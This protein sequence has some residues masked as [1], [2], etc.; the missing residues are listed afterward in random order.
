[1]DIKLFRLVERKHSRGGWLS[2]SSGTDNIALEN[3]W[4]CELT[5]Q[6][7]AW[8]NLKDVDICGIVHYRRFFMDYKLNSKK[9]SDDILSKSV[10]EEIFN[11]DRYDI[12]VPYLSSKH[13]GS[14]VLYKN[15]PLEKQDKHWVIIDEII[16]SKYPDYYKSFKKV[17]YGK[18]QL[19]WNMFIA[20]K[21]IFSSYSEW[22]FDVLKDYDDYIEQ[23]LH[24]ERIPRVDGFLTE[25]LLLVWIDKNIESKRIKHL[26]VKQTDSNNLSYN[27]FIRKAI[28]CNPLMLTLMKNIKMYVKILKEFYI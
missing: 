23:R 13:K 26:D 28:Y 25:L 7:W 9:F 2:D 19:W 15:L 11:S 22:M 12:I 18:K 8:K 5:A 14:S 20:R 3:P 1:M 17:I 16:A 24:E 6:Y 27:G 10:I 4:Y 21:D